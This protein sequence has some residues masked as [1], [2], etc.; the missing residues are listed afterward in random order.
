MDKDELNRR[1]L[2]ILTN[3]GTTLATLV[4]PLKRAVPDNVDQ[5]QADAKISKLNA[6]DTIL[7][8]KVE[9]DVSIKMVNKNQISF[10]THNLAFMSH[11]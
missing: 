1:A 8:N 6:E 7:Q 10:H 5:Q 11:N 4:N 9:H 3:F 2:E